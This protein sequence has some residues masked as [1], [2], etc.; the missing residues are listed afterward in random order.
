MA[1]ELLDD[2][3]A[4]IWEWHNRQTAPRKKPGGI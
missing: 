4:G 2:D 1:D 3:K